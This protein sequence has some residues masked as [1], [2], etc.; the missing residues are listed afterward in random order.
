MSATI[1]VPGVGP[2]KRAYVVAGV[3]VLGGVLVYAYWR[4]SQA[5]ATAATVP[6]VVDSTGTD[7]LT[8]DSTGDFNPG[9]GGGAFAPY[10]YDLFGNPLPPPTGAGSGGPYTT[11]SDWATAAETALQD[12]GTTLASA[13]LAVSRVLGGLSV[14][15]AQRDLF[16]QAVGILGQPPQGYPTPIKLTDDGSGSGTPP[17]GPLKAPTGLHVT[18]TTKTTVGLAWTPVP[19]AAHYRVYDSLSSTNVGD[20]ADTAIRIGGLPANH[21][22]H[23]YVRALD[24]HNTLGAKS[25]SVSAKTKK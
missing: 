25:G 2:T 19:G 15:S 16:L 5:T 18:S 24:P 6:A 13:A 21:T 23:F 12:G 4:R 10:G 7:G 1:N 14:S 3:G 20:S 9:T 22:V 11:N 17:G 8:Q